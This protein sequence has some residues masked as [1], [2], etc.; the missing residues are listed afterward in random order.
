MSPDQ[1]EKIARQVL[2]PAASALWPGYGKTRVEDY[3]EQAALSLA[4]RSLAEALAL[5]VVACG[6]P[7]D[8]A[9]SRVFR[10]GEL[11]VVVRQGAFSLLGVATSAHTKPLQV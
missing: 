10:A 7:M 9:R 2:L 5:G 6:N 3:R 1:A 4:L 8:A 11:D